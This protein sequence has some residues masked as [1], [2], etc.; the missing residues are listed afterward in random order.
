MKENLKIIGKINQRKTEMW[1]NKR[2]KNE[3]KKERKNEWMKCI[4]ILK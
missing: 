3:R 4:R 1:Y 2:K